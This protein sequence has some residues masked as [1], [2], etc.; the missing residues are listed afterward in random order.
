MLTCPNISYDVDDRNRGITNGGIGIIHQLV[1]KISPAGEINSCLELLKRHIPYHESDHVLNL[2]YNILS[3]GHCLQDIDLPKNFYQQAVINV[4]GTISPI[5]GRCK[6]G[7]DLSY[8]GQ[9]SYHPLLISLANTREPLYIINR[10]GNVPSHLYSAHW[11]DKSLDLVCPCFET[12]KI[13]SR[14]TSYA[15]LLSTI[16]ALKI[17]SIK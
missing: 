5:D 8:N 13:L 12:V 2:A 10:P 7:M 3:G 15:S 4:D 11:L 6:K 14:S 1:E 9:W 17:G 16:F